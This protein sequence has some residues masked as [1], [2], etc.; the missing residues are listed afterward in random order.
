MSFIF[1]FV[2]QYYYGQLKLC[3]N[4]NI[5]IATANRNIPCKLNIDINLRAE[6]MNNANIEENEN[7]F[8]LLPSI[9]ERDILRGSN[10][11]G[12]KMHKQ[13]KSLQPFPFGISSVSIFILL[14]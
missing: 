1:I 12:I 2:L 10:G 4:I 6:R 8:S 5:I 9:F 13:E 3:Q 11:I 7:R 14:K